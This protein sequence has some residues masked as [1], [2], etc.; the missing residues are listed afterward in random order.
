MKKL[1]ILFFIIILINNLLSLLSCNKGALADK[2]SAPLIDYEINE[3]VSNKFLGL[4]IIDSDDCDK[5]LK[6]SYKTSGGF[7]GDLNYGGISLPYDK[8]EG[9]Y[10]IS[11]DLTEDPFL[12]GKELS[13]NNKINLKALFVEQ[14][15]KPD[16]F[17][18]RVKYKLLAY[19]ENEYRLYNLIITSHPVMTI[20]NKG[21]VGDYNYPIPEDDV[22]VYLS[23]YSPSEY[24]TSEAKIHI[25]GGSSRYFPKA[26]YKINL[27]DSH[28]NS[29]DV[30]LLGLRKDNDWIL[31]PMYTDESKIRDVFSYSLWYE[32]S[33]YNNSYGL[34]N[35]VKIKYIELILNDIYWGLYGLVVPL[36]KKQNDLKDNLGEILC[37]N[38]SWEIPAAK[39]LYEAGNSESVQSINI[40]FPD[41][42]EQSDWNK[43]ASFTSLIYESSDTEF[44]DN[45][46]EYIE[47]DNVIDYWIFVN[48]I[49]GEDNGWK[50]MYIS[51][52]YDGSKYKSLLCPWD[53]DL[54]LGVTWDEKSPLFWFYSEHLIKIIAAGTLPNRFISLNIGDSKNKLKIRWNELRDDILSIESLQKRVDLLTSEI[55]LS[56]AWERDKTRWPEGGHAEDVGMIEDSVTGNGYIKDFI[57]KRINFLDNFIENI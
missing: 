7:L 40:K 49:S 6:N 57:E 51:F 36:D 15:I 3:N 43:I 10:Y 9:S 4:E 27:R 21:Y 30:N 45:I 34:E 2:A 20:N 23:L 26:G 28:D 44:Y 17:Q 13:Y 1:S 8:K 42:P 37:K 54:S 12:N 52:K 14:S 24:I 5:I 18:Y 39:L 47:I 38:E 53:C 46:L 41:N 22:S 33:A 19:N 31:I 50:N 16:N 55:V 29:N 32:L 11:A 48:L 35:G 56:G 25:R